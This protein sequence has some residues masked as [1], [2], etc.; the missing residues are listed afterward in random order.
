MV[1][2]VIVV[3]AVVAAATAAVVA[4]AVANGVE[5]RSGV[6]VKKRWGWGFV[7]MEWSPMPIC[8]MPPICCILTPAMM[9]WEANGVEHGS[10][11]Q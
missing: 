5:H 4:A 1:A 6:G 7:G 8:C 9:Y 11:F 10:V 2:A 3:A